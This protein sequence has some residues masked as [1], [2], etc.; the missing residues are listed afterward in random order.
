MN[1]EITNLTGR[2]AIVTGAGGPGCGR[3]IARRLAR[4]GASVVVTDIDEAGAHQTRSL[5]VAEGG[6]AAVV[7]A[8]VADE[9][10][11]RNLIGFAEATFGGLDIVVNNASA[12]YHPE[13]PFERWIETIQTD[14]FGAIYMTLHSLDAMRRRGGGAI[15]NMASVSAI[16]HGRK[17]GEVPGYDVAKAGVIRLTTTLGRLQREN[18]RVN[19][20]VPGW[21]A[22]PEVQ[23]Y[24]DSLTPEQR[25][26]RGVPATLIATDQ[27]AGAVVELATDESLAGRVMVWWNDQPR[28]LIPVGDQGY[29]RLE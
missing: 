16:G 19:C 23:G 24:V 27:I 15:V 29:E 14:L 4:D 2:T 8:N 10:A 11:V 6:R 12:L 18:I 28:R 25:Q 21:I 13:T 26:K 20:L 5:I 9:R 22:S 17:H 1:S 3:A 7:L